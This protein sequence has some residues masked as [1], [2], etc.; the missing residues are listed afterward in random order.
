MPLWHRLS[1]KNKLLLY[2]IY[3]LLSH[4]LKVKPLSSKR[5]RISWSLQTSGG[6][7]VFL[8][9][10]T[11]SDAPKVHP[12]SKIRGTQNPMVSYWRYWNVSFPFGSNKFGRLLIWEDPIIFPI[13]LWQSNFN[14]EIPNILGHLGLSFI[15]SQDLPAFSERSF[16][17]SL[18][19]SWAA[20]L[21]PP[22][23]FAM[24]GLEENNPPFSL[25]DKCPHKRTK[26]NLINDL[27]VCFC[28]P[29]SKMIYR[30]M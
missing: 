19:N 29:M 24:M 28:W 21:W 2:L 22:Y 9:V 25:E 7:M 15:V 23:L 1:G 6:S 4:T 13:F 3:I 27:N 8:T 30:K 12:T 10:F 14:N 16:S 26:M 5:C 11:A 18:W 20:H 17:V